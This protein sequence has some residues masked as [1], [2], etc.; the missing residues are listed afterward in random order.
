MRGPR[1][2][3]AALA[4]AA[5]LLVMACAPRASAC[6]PVDATTS[7]PDAENKVQV[8]LRLP[9]QPWRGVTTPRAAEWCLNLPAAHRV[10]KVRTFVA[11]DRGD[12]VEAAL[13]VVVH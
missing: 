12:L 6:T 5:L 9:E 1:W 4:L 2:R 10:T 11:T 8:E 7:P 3:L 13:H